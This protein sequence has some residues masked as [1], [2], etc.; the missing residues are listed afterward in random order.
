VTPSENSINP[1]PGAHGILEARF[2]ALFPL[3]AVQV[4]FVSL[5]FVTFFLPGLPADAK[6]RHHTRSSSADDGSSGSKTIH[7]G[8]RGG[9]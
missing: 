2:L 6:G 9:K 3:K 1:S 5:F 8:S 7:T 4:V